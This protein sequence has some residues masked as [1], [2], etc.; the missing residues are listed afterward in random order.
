MKKPLVLLF[1]IPFLCGCSGKTITDDEAY[2]LLLNF[3]TKLSQTTTFA[4]F[5]RTAVTTTATTK[6]TSFRQV[7]FQENFI[8]YYYVYEDL[9]NPEYSSTSEN[10][11]YVKDQ[12]IYNVSNDD[13]AEDPNEKIYTTVAYDQEYW[14]KQLNEEFESVKTSNTYN[15]NLLKLE[16]EKQLPETILTSKSDGETSLVE[17]VDRIDENGKVVQTK[18]YEFIDS[19]I[20]HI[21]DKDDEYKVVQDFQYKITRQ[22]PR[23]PSLKT[24]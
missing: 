24:A 5:E 10:W 8:H 14:Q 3:E 7:F 1:V 21:Y 19:L 17:R 18:T 9:Q 16:L 4:Y 12:L 20:S 6:S 2:Q 23:Y 11:I 22:E 13:S 15:I